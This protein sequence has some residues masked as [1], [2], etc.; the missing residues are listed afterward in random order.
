M[1]VPRRRRIEAYKDLDGLHWIIP[2]EPYKNAACPRVDVW[3]NRDP[4]KRIGNRTVLN[5]HLVIRQE[6]GKANPDVIIL[7]HGQAYDLID[8]LCSAVENP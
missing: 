8:A 3:W 7:T 1:E 5:E 2:L 4:R 6:S